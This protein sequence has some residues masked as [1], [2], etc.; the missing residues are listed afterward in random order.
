[1]RIRSETL[2]AGLKARMKCSTE[3]RLR[4]ENNGTK[5]GTEIT[6]SW[7]CPPLGYMLRDSLLFADDVL[8]ID[9]SF[10]APRAELSKASQQAAPP[11]Y[12]LPHTRWPCG[13]QT[14]TMGIP[15]TF[16]QISLRIL[17]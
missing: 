15:C 16:L 9:S 7:I 5:S 4:L 17:S 13:D 8:V 6:A 14:S 2:V 10:E 1:M 12:M 3:T 11:S